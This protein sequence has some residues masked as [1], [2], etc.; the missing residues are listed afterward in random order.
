M[1]QHTVQ[2]ANSQELHARDLASIAWAFAK[3]AMAG[4]K[5]ASM[6]AALAAAAQRRMG[7]FSPQSLANTAWAFAT[8]CQNDASLFTALTRAAER[9]MG[10]FKP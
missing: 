7:D 2:A 10:D 1:V 6:F 5:D 4:Q 9:C 3:I 8:A